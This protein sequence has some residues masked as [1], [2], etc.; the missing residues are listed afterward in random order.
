MKLA[1]AW[2]LLITVAA[3]GQTLTPVQPAAG[4]ID[5]WILGPIIIVLVVIGGFLYLRKKNPTAAAMVATTAS[6]DVQALV[7][8]LHGWAA[9]VEARFRGSGTGPEPPTVTT[10]PEP[11]PP[12]APGKSGQAGT[13]SITVTGDPATDLPAMVTQYNAK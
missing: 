13:F 7:A 9:S 6:A 1:L 10:L 11:A 3:W 2:I 8:D 12:P 4:G 5:W